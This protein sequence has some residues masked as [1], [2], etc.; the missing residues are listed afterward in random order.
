MHEQMRT[1]PKPTRYPSQETCGNSPNIRTNG[2]VKN[3]ENNR[4][5]SRH[6]HDV[7]CTR[8]TGT[9]NKKPQLETYR[10]EKFKMKLSHR[11]RNSIKKCVEP[12][13]MCEFFLHRYSHIIISVYLSLR[14]LTCIK[15]YLRACSVQPRECVR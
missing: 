10:S 9:G 14:I 13:P 15:L 6:T 11:L 2:E 4:Q 5:R 1:D 7:Y 3:I 12:V 8:I